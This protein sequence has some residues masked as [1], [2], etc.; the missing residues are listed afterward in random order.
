MAL[1]NRL[2]GRFSSL[3][4]PLAITTCLLPATL[5]APIAGPI[6]LRRPP[7]GPEPGRFRTA[8]ATVPCPRMMRRKPLL[9]PLQQTNPRTATNRALPRRRQ[10]IMLDLDQGSA[11]SQW[12]SPGSGG[13]YSAPGRLCWLTS[14]SSPSAQLNPRTS[15]S[16]L[17]AAVATPP[18]PLLA[19]M[20]LRAAPRAGAAKLAPSQAAT[21]RLPS[22]LSISRTFAPFGYRSSAYAQKR[23]SI[24]AL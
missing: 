10:A 1:A 13:A 23:A 3:P 6:P 24:S 4:H 16:P 15:A 21:N 2:W 19:A 18:G 17:P 14:C 22:P 11:N 5:L 7:L 9:A 20:R 12:S 8:L